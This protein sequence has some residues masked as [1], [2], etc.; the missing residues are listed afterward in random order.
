V[1]K[2]W[3]NNAWFLVVDAEDC[4]HWT[5]GRG[6]ALAASNTLI[7]VDEGFL[8]CEQYPSRLKGV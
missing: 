2:V 3:V 5:R 7:G 8:H 1:A 4:A 6:V